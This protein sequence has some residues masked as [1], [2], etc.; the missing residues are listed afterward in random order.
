MQIGEPEEGRI[1]K[2]NDLGCIRGVGI[3]QGI[4]QLRER[5][6]DSRKS[7]D[8]EKEESVSAQSVV[9]IPIHPGETRSP[10][11]GEAA[12]PMRDSR[13]PD[14]DPGNADQK[15]CNGPDTVQPPPHI[16]RQQILVE[17]YNPL[18]GSEPGRIGSG[19]R[20]EPIAKYKHAAG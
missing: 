17:I 20:L 16:S 7:P 18:D 9:Q 6:I 11:Y 2:A 8:G 4:R 5:E 3:D 12:A 1:G 19:G 14:D 13:P 10:I 15:E